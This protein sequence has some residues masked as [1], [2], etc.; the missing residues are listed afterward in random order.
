M[1]ILVQKGKNNPYHV[2]G[3]RRA[4]LMKEYILYD[5]WDDPAILIQG[6]LKPEYYI[7]K[8]IPLVFWFLTNI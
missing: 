7:R 3:Q 6:G 2:P 1:Q 4:Q 8:R 5:G